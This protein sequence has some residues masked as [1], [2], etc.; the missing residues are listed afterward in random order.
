MANLFYMPLRPAYDSAGV[1]VPGAKAWFTTTGTNT[2]ATVYSNN[3][4]TVPRT[5]PVVFDGVGKPPTTYLDPAKTY[6]VRIYARDAEVGVDTPLEEYDPYVPGLWADA[7]A[8]QPVADAAAAS[9]LAAAASAGEAAASAAAAAA[10]IVDATAIEAA[11][12][13]VIAALAAGGSVSLAELEASGLPLQLEWFGASGNGT[14]TGDAAAMTAAIA[15]CNL[16]ATDGF[17]TG[18]PEIRL[19]AGTYVFGA[20]TFNITYP[21]R[22]RGNGRGTVLKWTNGTTGFRCQHGNTT[23]ATGVQADS[24][25]NGRLDI[26]DCVLDGG[27]TAGAESNAYAIHAR[28][29]IIASRLWFKDWPNDGC[30][31]R[32]ELADGAVL[33][34]C[35]G[36]VVED[37]LATNCRRA[38]YS[39]GGDVNGCSFKNI[40]GF[41]NRQGSIHDASFLGNTYSGM[42]Q[43]EA[44]GHTALTDGV[45]VP[46]CFVSNAGN[47]YFP[48]PGQ[49]TGASTNAPS[50]TTANN[51][52]WVYWKAGAPSTGIP[53]WVSGIIVRVGACYYVEGA[54]NATEMENPYCEDDGINLFDQC[55]HINGSRRLAY[56]WSLVA[57]VF[58]APRD[59][60]DGPSGIESASGG[61]RS[62][63]NFTVKGSFTAPYPAFG[64][65]AGTATDTISYWDNTLNF[66]TAYFRS[67]SAGV[68]QYDAIILG[69][70]S[71]AGLR[72]YGRTGILLGTNA[73]TAGT[74]YAKLDDTGLTVWGRIGFGSGLAIGG[75]ST[76]ATSKS[77]AATALNAQCGEVTMNNASLAAG[78]IVSFTMANSKAAAK[79]L[80]TV[81]H[82]SGG[83]I[84]AYSV[85]AVASAGT[86]T[87]YV[88]NNTAGALGEAL[89]LRFGL[90]GGTIT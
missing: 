4:L 81:N 70:H 51:T 7:G 60:V 50:G 87:F 43:A 19:G 25:H 37:I 58:S 46:C 16:Q 17:G 76:Q 2:P 52:W 42:L 67:W 59:G 57:G 29:Q 79:D 30:Y 33:G 86:I 56:A 75:T 14:G 18:I 9:E 48:K 31:L 15:Y 80:V 3:G 1:S 55:A 63:G 49:E 66:H 22:I 6:R 78:A 13:A 85:E 53:A 34:N 68:P 84:G 23:G 38:I 61:L 26:A 27:Y 77:T 12:T 69:A 64:A 40:I 5:N 90:T 73:G 41:G 11:K 21:I 24:G 65:T 10:V 20:N 83:T 45:T 88:R 62:I 71:N 72:L 36:S 32:A 8:L 82:V 35:N 39:L 47:L 44:N 74:D 54:S 28:T 89:V